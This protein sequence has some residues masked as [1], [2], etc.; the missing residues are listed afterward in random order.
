MCAQQ[1]GRLVA[2]PVLDRLED[3]GVLVIRCVNVR[4]LGEVKS[5]NHADAVRR[6]AVHTRHLDKALAVA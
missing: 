2:A 5:A 3:F 6:V 1:Q 4:L